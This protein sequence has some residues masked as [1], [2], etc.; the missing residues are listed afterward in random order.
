MILCDDIVE[1]LALIPDKSLRKKKVD[2]KDA[3]IGT[4]GCTVGE[5]QAAQQAIKAAVLLKHKT[6]A[7]ALRAMDTK[8]DGVL[9]RDEIVT[10]LQGYRLIKHIDYYTGAVHG[11]ITMAQVDT[12]IDFVDDNGDGNINYKE[13]TKVLVA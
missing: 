13:F 4:R 12:L 1:L 3:P 11:S 6:I 8:G 10:M 9:S 2:P 7:Q 5:L